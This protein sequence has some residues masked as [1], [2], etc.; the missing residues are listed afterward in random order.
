MQ[1]AAP[2]IT[3]G[4]L[5]LGIGIFTIISQRISNQKLKF[6]QKQQESNQEIYNLMLAQHG[7]LEEGKKSEQKRV[8]EELHDGILGQM[9]GIR[10]VLSGLNERTDPAA[11]EQREELIGKLQE[12]EEE[13]RTISHELNASAYQK[14]YNFIISIKELIHNVQGSSGIAIA[15]DYEEH[16]EWDRLNG[17]IK[18]NTYRIVQELLQN[19]V[20]HAKCKTINVSF[21]KDKNVLHLVVTDDGVGFD[22]SKGKKGIGLKNII[23]RAKKLN[24]TL[25]FNSTPGTGTE[26]GIKIPNI[27]LHKEN[28]KVKDLRTTVLEANGTSYG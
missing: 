21:T 11:V 9:L 26:V 16:F 12:L 4:L 15:F 2:G 6:K 13:I 1:Y 14:V 27:D 20:K 3:V 17:D 8:S 18:I 25:E 28:P 5:V 22:N 24:A 10:L 23:S 19:C 7:K